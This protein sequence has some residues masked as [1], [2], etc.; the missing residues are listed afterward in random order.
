MAIVVHNAGKQ[1][2]VCFC[3]AARYSSVECHV[4]SP[5]ERPIDIITNF[6]ITS[7][8]ETFIRVRFNYRHS[9]EKEQKLSSRRA[10]LRER[11]PRPSF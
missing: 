8:Y 1:F 6:T 3:S 9:S 7:P 5:H 10:L 11:E 2:E 4:W